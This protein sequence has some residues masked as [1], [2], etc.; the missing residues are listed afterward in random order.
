[1]AR[2]SFI[3]TV[4]LLTAGDLN[5]LDRLAFG[6]AQRVPNLMPGEHPSRRVGRGQ[7]FADHRPYVPGDDLRTIDW[8]AL[9]RTDR[10]FV[11]RQE[12][13]SQQRVH[14]LLD[15]SA[16]MAYRGQ[17]AALNPRWA[18]GPSK[19]RYACS[20]A[21]AVAHVCAR[22]RDPVGFSVLHNA[23]VESWP[24]A[25]EPGVHHARLQH[26]AALEP[27]GRAGLA[28]ALHTIGLGTARHAV[29]LVISD[30][31]EQMP[32][33]L[34][35]LSALVGRGAQW[36]V[37]QVL[38]PDE[39]ALP[40]VK[41]ALRFVDS[42]SGEAVVASPA[43]IADDYRQRMA[44][45]IERWRAALASLGIEHRLITTDRPVVDA[46]GDWVFNR[47]LRT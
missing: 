26:A 24:T 45:R 2:E 1:M 22:Q 6:G 23:R 11:K 39:V 5:R 28:K 29:T 17:D 32:D 36:M 31:H 40:V 38:H 43:R 8:K 35:A 3:Q 27:S 34:D 9:G 20:L 37:A 42:E 13:T 21:A 25:N 47:S 15:A 41:G 7:V 18:T 19:H 44:Q 46:L 33:V 10:L 14:L 30:L 16:S 4:P 12:Q